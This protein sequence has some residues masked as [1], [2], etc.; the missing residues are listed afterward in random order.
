MQ[1]NAKNSLQ[2]TKQISCKSYKRVTDRL[3]ATDSG[4]TIAQFCTLH[5]FT[6]TPY[7][8]GS[9]NDVAIA[10]FDGS[11]RHVPKPEDR[12][13]CDNNLP[14]KTHLKFRRFRD[15]DPKR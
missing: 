14:I 2:L 7:S 9:S 4:E 5:F 15:L 10:R 12:Q 3:H 11:H 13:S 1:N 6:L 8:M